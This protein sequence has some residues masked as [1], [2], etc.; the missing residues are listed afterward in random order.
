MRKPD[1]KANYSPKPDGEAHPAADEAQLKPRKRGERMG[2]EEGG[3]EGE[4]WGRR[5]GEKPRFW[6][7]FFFPLPSYPGLP[8][9]RQSEKLKLKLN[10]E[11]ESRPQTE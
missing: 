4:N 5:E 10:M 2:R 3:V 11:R 1:R 6:R 7:F 8:L 9:H